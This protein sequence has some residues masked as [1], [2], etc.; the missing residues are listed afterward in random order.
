M[1]SLIKLASVGLVLAMS[2]NVAIASDEDDDEGI[3]AVT[4]TNLTKG[5]SFTPILAASTLKGNIIFNTGSPASDELEIIAE[6]G[7]NQPLADSLISSGHA[8]ETVSSAG[9]LGPGKSVTLEVKMSEKFRFVSV[10]AMLVP[11]NDGFIAA[12]SIRGPKKKGRSVTKYSSVYDSGTEV[13]DELCVNMPGPFCAGE[14][15]NPAGGEGFVHINIG[16]HDIGDIASSQFDWRNP[17]AKI[18]VK[19]IK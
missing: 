16:M 17:A 8:L 11:T 18:V 3:Y 5:Q 19:R 10:A 15:F 1:N 7:N 2:A 14:G 4:I 12:N 9:L 6:G 13:N